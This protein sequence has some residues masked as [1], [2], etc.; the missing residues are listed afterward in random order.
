MA[1]KSGYPPYRPFLPRPIVLRKPLGRKKPTVLDPDTGERIPKPHGIPFFRDERHTR[2]T[3]WLYRALLRETGKKDVPSHGTTQSTTAS[4]AA[5]AAA[6]L[7]E[8][9]EHGRAAA[10]SKDTPGDRPDQHSQITQRSHDTTLSRINLPALRRKIKEDWRKRKGWTSVPNTKGFLETQYTLLDT[11]Y[12][13]DQLRSP[14]SFPNGVEVEQDAAETKVDAARQSSATATGNG[15]DGGLIPQAT[16]QV[17]PARVPAEK[18]PSRRRS[19]TNSVLMIDRSTKPTPTPATLPEL[20]TYSR[21][22]ASL[23][24]FKDTRLARQ[25]RSTKLRNVHAPSGVRVA[26]FLRPTPFNPALLRLKPQPVKFTMMISNRIKARNNR[27]KNT[28]ALDTIE[29][30]IKGEVDFLQAV[31]AKNSHQETKYEWMKE[32][33][34]TRAVYQESYEREKKRSEEV[35]T[36]EMIKRVQ[37][38]KSERQA[39]WRRR[40]ELR[41]ATAAA[42]QA[43]RVAEG[44]GVTDAGIPSK[45]TKLDS[46]TRPGKRTQRGHKGPKGLSSDDKPVSEE[47]LPRT[48]RQT[49]SRAASAP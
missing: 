30:D 4:R 37:E 15:S 33:S 23:Q 34:R 28:R 14:S 27:L 21:A 38:A 9:E 16:A 25:S 3:K 43:K 39:R 6:R 1:F 36:W 26:G 5:S 12:L 35:F 47:R 48:T 10:H 46:A 24:A 11:L 17:I 40:A 18:Y 8:R 41:K 13:I 42:L 49:A 2:P 19:T 20:I 22:L 45:E 44:P 29:S 7:T 32:I 31:G